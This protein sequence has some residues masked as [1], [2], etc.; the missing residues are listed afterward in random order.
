MAL[1]S[2]LAIWYRFLAD[3]LLGSVTVHDIPLP[4]QPPSQPLELAQVPLPPEEQPPLPRSPPLPNDQVS[5]LVSAVT[6]VI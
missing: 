5:H 4:S 3:V 1:V 6:F 2:V